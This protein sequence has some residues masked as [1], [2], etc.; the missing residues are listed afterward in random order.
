MINK[1]RRAQN[2]ASQAAFRARQQQ[3]TKELEEKLTQLEKEHEDL[4]QSY[5]SLQL[6]HSITKQELET[7]QRSNSNQYGMPLASTASHWATEFKVET[8]DPHLID[9]AEFYYHRD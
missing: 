8:S 6:Q 3:R 7:L 1:R 2:R 4:S 9:S 5:E